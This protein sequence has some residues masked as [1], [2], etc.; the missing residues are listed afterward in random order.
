[1]KVS[2]R[3][4]IKHISLDAVETAQYETL[5]FQSKIK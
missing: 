4:A 1:M 5:L 2:H 3:N